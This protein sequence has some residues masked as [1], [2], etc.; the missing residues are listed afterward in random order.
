MASDSA[1]ETTKAREQS[2]RPADAALSGEPQT[3]LISTS[4]QAT[5]HE[6]IVV[7][8]RDGDELFI[9]LDNGRPANQDLL[10]AATLYVRETDDPDHYTAYR[11]AEHHPITAPDRARLERLTARPISETTEVLHVA[12]EH[13]SLH[14]LES[15]PP[16]FVA[17]VD[18]SE[19]AVAALAPAIALSEWYGRPCTI[20]EVTAGSDD[21]DTDHAI[22]CQLE[23][24]PLAS[25]DVIAVA[26]ADLDG[27]V[28]DLMRQGQIVVASAFGVW[29]G[30]GRLHGTLNGLIRHNAPAIVGIGPNVPSDWKPRTEDPIVVCVDDSEHAHHLAAKLDPFLRPARARVVVIHVETG[31]TANVAVAQQVADQIHDRYGLPAQARSFPDESAAAGIAIFA[32]RVHAQLVITH[33]WHR[34]T[35]GEPV[36]S[37]TSLSSIAHVPCPVVVL[38]E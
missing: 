2:T 3:V 35:P 19:R 37:S 4:A 1:S 30:D 7:A 12:G 13:L 23:D 5:G 6:R 15:E 18:G 10:D 11:V 32:S 27:L 31:Q 9:P 38:G 36:V 22:V 20:V 24:T 33:S 26:K 29:A 17:L 8:F 25:S 28:F 34:P 14:D 21:Q 16:G